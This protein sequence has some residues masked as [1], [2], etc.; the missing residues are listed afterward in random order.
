MDLPIDHFRLLGVS[1]AADAQTVLRTLQL[2]LDRPPAQTYTEETLQARAD[3]LRS[4]AEMLSDDNR[5]PAYEAALT[6]LGTGGEPLMAAL[7]LPSSKEVAGL[8]LLLEAGQPLECFNLARRNLHPPQAPAL[9]SGREAD[10][11]QLAGQACLAAARDLEDRRHYQSAAQTLED[12]LVLLQRMGQRPELRESMRHALEQMA[13]YRVLD[14]LSRDASVVKERQEGLALLEE[15]VQRRGGLEGEADPN[16][17]LMQ[18]EAFFRQIRSFLTLQEQLDLFNRWSRQGSAVAELLATTA[19]TASGFAQRKPDRIAEAR[20][21]LLAADPARHK[22]ML[23]NLHLL[24]GDVGAAR[25]CFEAGASPD[26]KAWAERQSA[27]DP[28]GQL[29]AWCREWLARDVLPGY[30]DLEA[31]PDLEAY[32][33]DRDV[34]T[35]VERE[36]RR[37]GRSFLVPAAPAPPQASPPDW[38]VSSTKEDFSGFA[39][40]AQATLNA[41]LGTPGTP[42]DNP[43]RSDT[44]GDSPLAA[45][46]AAVPDD[47]WRSRFSWGRPAPLDLDEEND[48]EED[49]PD[50]VALDSPLARWR[51]HLTHRWR[52][53]GQGGWNPLL[54]WVVPAVAGLGGLLLATSW[55]GQRPKAPKALA[56]TL[57]S[58]VVQPAPVK[59]PSG[60]VQPVAT[61]TSP[62]PSP[63]PT[64]PQP[65]P[66]K[67]DQPT[68]TE[69]RTLL[70]QWLATKRSV[71]GGESM[72]SDLERLARPDPIARLAAE[73]KSDAARGE[74]QR[75]DVDLKSVRIQS[76]SPS[77]IA[78]LAEMN[79]SDRR[80]S[81]DG[82]VVTST[83]PTILR[84]VYVFGRDGQTWRLVATQPA[85]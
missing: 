55:M 25:T 36:D 12:G 52:N 28:L 33:N 8:L 9:G 85:P 83:P 6:T 40:W 84:N 66:L 80:L 18:F 51:D 38:L 22:T 77:R 64:G 69:L 32:F 76:Q 81:S 2:R 20:Q 3:L 27:E 58:P 59:P 49:D 14:L 67:T 1:P 43:R 35:W 44:S 21:R 53:K 65:T 60:A 70:E 68:E 19:L 75:I 11:T 26:L 31:E 82:K 29:C 41:P 46:P 10:L 24:L 61:G 17:S 39:S 79:Y 47:S 30:R 15:L 71:L 4:S 74:R 5:R 42:A 50:D 7:D 23:A 78:L 34:R 37:Q 54:P 13:P 16:F 63:A 48:D 57:P 56:P 72:P 62:A 45:D 73:Q